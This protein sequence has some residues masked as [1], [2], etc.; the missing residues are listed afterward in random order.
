MRDT[1]NGP[2]NIGFC[3]DSI[4][5]L[6]GAARGSPILGSDSVSAASIITTA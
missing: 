1:T 6:A 5:D 4:S 3:V 2:P